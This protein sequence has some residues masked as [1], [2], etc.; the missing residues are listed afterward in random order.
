MR[1]RL[2]LLSSALTLVALNGALGACGGSSGGG[3][4]SS[5][6]GASDGTLP[7]DT[8]TP[9]D[10]IESPID[11][12]DD[13]TATDG[14]ELPDV[15]VDDTDGSDGVLTPDL[16]QPDLVPV[17]V[18]PVPDV[19]ADFGDCSPAGGP[20][21][22]Y[23]LQNPDCPDHISP[24]PTTNPGVPITLEGVIV[25]GRF[26]D[27][28]F[29]QEPKGGPYS[30]L[31][32]F[33]HG[34]PTDELEPGTIIT[35]EGNYT[36]YFDNTQLY[37]TSFEVTGKTAA[38]EP[39]V[40]GHPSHLATE[41]PIA[42]LFEGVLVRV[43]D[44]KTIHTK[45][46]CPEE[47]GEFAVTGNLRIDDMGVKWKAHLGDEFASITG[48]LYYGFGNFKIEPRTDADLVV[49]KE[50]G[51]TA[52][53]KCIAS[54]CQVQASNPGTKAVV[55]T[56]V[57]ADA[58]GDDTGQEWIELYNKGNTAVDISGWELRDCGSQAWPIAFGSL[59]I[60]PGKYLVLG[61]SS[62]PSMN[63]GAPVDVAYGTAF[64]LPNTLG[65]VLLFDGSGPQ[66]QLVD[67]T[68]YSR[69]DPWT[70]FKVGKSLERVSATADGTLPESWET[71][72]KEYGTAGNLGTPGAKNSAF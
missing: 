63:G 9:A 42:E 32:I 1:N 40:P 17:D 50:G 15:T 30:G 21:N 47:Y 66:A 64:Y 41:S 16:V 67:Q 33:S 11:V 25:T 6:V 2:T 45:P 46:D 4:G 13:V 8:E 51:A 28:F 57:M 71:G 44:V 62:S 24:E 58:V 48:P 5:D 53:S 59:V 35:V 49:T 14:A 65:S 34:V 69:F 26:S 61:Y 29:V 39:W 68:R 3:S 60:Q 7:S 72:T 56:E 52:I 70:T 54:E 18:P 20:R 19:E 38:P 22:I 37:L 27:T 31:T 12:Q 23:D 43:E 55:I 10:D 36:E